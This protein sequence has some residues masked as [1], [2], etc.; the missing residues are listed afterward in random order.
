MAWDEFA[1]RLRATLRELTDRCVLIVAAAGKAGYVQF[2]AT[3]DELRVEA[4]GPA[5][6]AGPAAHA[7]DD[8]VLLAAGWTAPTRSAPNWSAELPLPALSAEYAALAD[9]CV[10]ALRDVYRL[11]GPEALGYQAWRDPARQP[12]GVTWSQ[13]QIAALDPGEDPLPLPGLGLPRLSQ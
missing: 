1:D 13:E 11:P 10:V 3:D 4:A 7:D 8:P 5:F 2:S 9:R 6:T 12:A